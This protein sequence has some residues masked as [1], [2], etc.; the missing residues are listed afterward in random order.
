MQAQLYRMQEQQKYCS[1]CTL[2]LT[3]A[4][5]LAILH[6]YVNVCRKSERERGWERDGERGGG[7]NLHGW[8]EG[9]REHRRCR[10]SCMEMKNKTLV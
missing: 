7:M 10:N 9:R 1:A 2:K 6:V 5:D 3:I 8:G 4:R